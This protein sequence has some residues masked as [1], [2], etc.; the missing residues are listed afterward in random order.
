MSRPQVVAAGSVIQPYWEA[1]VLAQKDAGVWE[2]FCEEVNAEFDARGLDPSG[3]LP[4]YT[5][6]NLNSWFRNA[7]Y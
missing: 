6:Q 1:G 7:T 4:R 3:A 2:R 5:L